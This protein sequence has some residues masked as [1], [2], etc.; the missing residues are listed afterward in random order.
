MFMRSGYRCPIRRSINSIFP[1]RHRGTC[2]IEH[3]AER[4]HRR[5]RRKHDDLASFGRERRRSING[6]APFVNH[7]HPFLRESGVFEAKGEIA[8]AESS[9]DSVLNGRRQSLE[10]RIPYPR[11]VAPVSIAIAEC[12]E[13]TWRAPGLEQ[14][15]DRGIEARGVLHQDEPQH[16]AFVLARLE[17][18]ARPT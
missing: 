6:R 10:V 11:H 1:K 4:L 15:T 13:E 16:S 2:A 18:A 5:V 8:P 9:D 14:R 17:T 12:R 3:R 7:F